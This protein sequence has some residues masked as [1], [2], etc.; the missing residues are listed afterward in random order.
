MCFS[1][2]GQRFLLTLPDYVPAAKCKASLAELIPKPIK[3]KILHEIGESGYQHTHIVVLIQSRVK[4]ASKKKWNTFR[5]TIGDYNLKPISTDEHFLNAL[6]YETSEVKKK[7]DATSKVVLDEIGEWE[8]QIPYHVECIRF[9]QQCESWNVV[10]T[11]HTYS[12]YICTKLNWA[13]EVYQH[14]RNASFEFPS[15][16]PYTWQ[17]KVIEFLTQKPDNRTVHWFTDYLGGSGKSDLS[18]WLIAHRNAFLCD[19]GGQKDIAFAY[20][21]QP[22]V[23]FD[24]SRDM[25]DYCPY[26]VMEAFKNGRMFSAKYQSCL[27][28]FKPPHVIV[29]ANFPPKKEKLS[30]DRWNIIQLEDGETDTPMLSTRKTAHG[31]SNNT[32]RPPENKRIIEEMSP[33]APRTSR[34][35]GSVICPVLTTIS[36]E[37][38]YFDGIGEIR[39]SPP[40]RVGERVSHPGWLTKR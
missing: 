19:S 35:F 11:D 5:E 32:K 40:A 6:K 15:G 24:L 25:E 18:N 17:Q 38:W 12:E 9:I 39:E 3:L 21:N 8:P 28:T 20:D 31:V 13:R 2:Q 16:E 30:M 14:S 22:I 37:P 4:L 27:K 36:T 29:F 1:F 23:I 33:T 7:T 10:I 26:R 34:E